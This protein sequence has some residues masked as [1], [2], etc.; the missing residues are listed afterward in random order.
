MQRRT[1]GRARC[2]Q[3]VFG[4]LGVPQRSWGRFELTGPTAPGRTSPRITHA[5]PSMPAN[6][7]RRCIGIVS[8]ATRRPSAVI[9]RG[10]AAGCA[11][12][13]GVEDGAPP[14]C[15]QCCY[16]PD[17]R[18][19]PRLVMFPDA[20]LAMA[21]ASLLSSAVRGVAAIGPSMSS[22]GHLG[23]T[24]GGLQAAPGHVRFQER[25]IADRFIA[26]TTT[27]QRKSALSPSNLVCTSDLASRKR[28]PRERRSSPQTVDSGAQNV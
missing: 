12:A 10:S 11:G 17:R 21:P 15:V 6:G 26:Q 3:E 23:A 20:R 27:Y 25:H 14:A 22:W 28:N 24:G 1:L 7:Q 5:P 8:R 2:R 18:Q 13:G 9:W 19:S 16:V 4:L